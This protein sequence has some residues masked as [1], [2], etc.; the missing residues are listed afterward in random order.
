MISTRKMKIS[1][2]QMNHANSV[3]CEAGLPDT[4]PV[5]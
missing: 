4:P 3:V 2:E 5:L 1:S